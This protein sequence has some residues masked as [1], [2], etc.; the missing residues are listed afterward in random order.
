MRETRSSRLLRSCVLA[1]AAV[2]LLAA[3]AGPALAADYSVSKYE[4]NARLTE[5]GDLRVSDKRTIQLSTETTSLAWDVPVG[6]GKS[7][8]FATVVGPEGDIYDRIHSGDPTQLKPGS[9]LESSNLGVTHI[10]VAFKKPA[11]GTVTVS[12]DYVAAR[13]GKRWKD[14]S[15]LLWDFIGETWP[16]ATDQIGLK[17]QLPAGTPPSDLKVFV[18]G[19]EQVQVSLAAA[20]A[21]PSAVDTTTGDNPQLGVVTVLAKGLAANTPMRVRVLMP[22]AAVPGAVES[23]GTHAPQVLAAERQY[24]A[25]QAPK[26]AAQ[27]NDDLIA[28]LVGAVV[29]IVALAVVWWLWR[30]RAAR[31]Q[32]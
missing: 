4:G 27:A 6:V 10:V 13:V 18:H 11:N 22:A 30:R 3:T 21:G 12:A 32:A 24:V 26:R 28:W 17:I 25:A 16:A 8:V 9:Y 2:G 19:P 15:E 29:A 7:V 31:G 23:T 1:A 20:P 5:M 14:V